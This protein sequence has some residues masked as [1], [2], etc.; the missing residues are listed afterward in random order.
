MLIIR[1]RNGRN[2][3]KR[4][5]FILSI[6]T[7]LSGGY[8]QATE[9]PND[10]AGWYERPEWEMTELKKYEHWILS[11]NTRQHTLG[12]AIIKARRDRVRLMSELTS[13]EMLELAVVMKDFENAL[14]KHP[15]FGPIGMAYYQLGNGLFQLHFHVIPRYDSVRQFE[16]LEWTDIDNSQPPV[17][18]ENKPEMSL[19][20]KI[21]DTLLP[22]LN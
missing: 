20:M 5:L 12:S 9:E 22:Y 2:F 7:V 19:L 14:D 16:G 8:V 17:F 11:V 21:R 1:S 13:E 18:G 6:V 15:N 4:I 10:D 3:M